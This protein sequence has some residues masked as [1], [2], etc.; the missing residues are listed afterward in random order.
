[1]FITVG[2]LQALRQGFSMSG[3]RGMTVVIGLMMGNLASI[4]PM[5]LVMSEKIL[6]GGRRVSLRTSIDI[7]ELVSLYQTRRL[8]LD[9]IITGRYPLEKINEAIASFEKGEAIRNVIMF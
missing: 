4:M 2:S 5:E 7:P 3:P 8:K 6:T 9:E 1:M